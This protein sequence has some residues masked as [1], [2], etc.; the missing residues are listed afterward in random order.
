MQEHTYRNPDS[1]ERDGTVLRINGREFDARRNDVEVVVTVKPRE[2]YPVHTVWQGVA[3]GSY[4]KVAEGKY[5][6]ISHSHS[7]A[8]ILDFS[9][10]DRIP[11]NVVF[12]PGESDDEDED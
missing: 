8:E 4:T 11:G 7:G 2:H 12:V 6:Y 1:I 10:D 9:G 3:L 5:L